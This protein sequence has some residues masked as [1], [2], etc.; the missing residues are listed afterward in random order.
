MNGTDPVKL[1]SAAYPETRNETYALIDSGASG[2]FG[3]LEDV[4]YLFSLV[5]GSRMVS[6]GVWIAPCNTRQTMTFSFG[7]RDYV[8]Q[9]SEWLMGR[10]STNTYEC[11][12]WPV[13][14]A[15]S[16]DGI[17]WQLG[18]PF[19]RS[20]YSVFKCVPHPTLPFSRWPLT[21]R[22]LAASPVWGSKAS[23]SH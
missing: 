17:G 13:A 23:K 6:D 8:L 16:G 7:G 18:T 4:E 22:S 10:V 15:P 1:F 12:A 14:L 5:D 20:V 2:I 11:L 19:L 9:P 3:P 21:V